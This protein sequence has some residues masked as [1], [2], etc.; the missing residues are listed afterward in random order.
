M[1]H[2]SSSRRRASRQWDHR[3][4][5]LSDVHVD[6]AEQTLQA[7]FGV[8]ACSEHERHLRPSR[9]QLTL[10]HPHAL[11][12]LSCRD[13]DA[14]RPSA[15]G[16]RTCCWSHSSIVRRTRTPHTLRT[17]GLEFEEVWPVA[18]PPPSYRVSVFL[19]AQPLAREK[20]S[21]VCKIAACP[22][23]VAI[24]HFD[25]PKCVIHTVHESGP[26]LSTVSGAVIFDPTDRIADL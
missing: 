9:C 20:L 17:D 23:W 3:T 21:S 18:Q 14:F 5:L 10:R 19:S 13:S 7:V 2:L 26:S 4:L 22:S 6:T 25:S 8:S 1:A 11:S 24:D 15:C 12:D 16:S